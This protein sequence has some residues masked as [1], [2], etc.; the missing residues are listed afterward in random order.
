[1]PLHGCCC[2]LLPAACCL[3]PAACRLLRPPPPLACHSFAHP[4]LSLIA[5]TREEDPYGNSTQ[6]LDDPD[7]QFTLL[8][9]RHYLYV[10]D[11]VCFQCGATGH[12]GSVR[13]APYCDSCDLF[14]HEAGHCR[15]ACSTCGG[16]HDHPTGPDCRQPHYKDCKLWGHEGRD[17]PLQQC[18]FCQ[19]YG[20]AEG[21]FPGYCRY[22]HP[23]GHDSEACLTHGKRCSLCREQGHTWQQCPPHT[24]AARRSSGSRQP[25]GSSAGGGRQHGASREVPS[26]WH[27]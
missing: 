11:P 10:A 17:C 26:Q 9:N 19:W 7:A 6:G 5:H 24:R 1:V 13:E 8:A 18:A 20:H 15:S 23:L 12:E 3:L 14:G 21:D 16:H 4:C 25:G 27:Y 22:C 2:C